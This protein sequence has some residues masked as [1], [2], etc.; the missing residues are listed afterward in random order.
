MSDT[1]AAISTPVAA[2]GIGVIRISGDE[3]INIADKI[4]KTTSGKSLCSLKGYT[5]AHGKVVSDGDT[6]DECVALVFRAP[7]SYTGE[8]TVE[9]SCMAEYLSQIRCGVL[10]S[11]PVQDL[12]KAEN[13]QSV[14]FLTAKWIFQRLKLLW[15]LSLQEVRAQ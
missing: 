1:I 12:L 13:S 11:M 5:A 14:L 3:A 7:R 6:V 9:I 8:N 2:G 4:I 10:F 15:I